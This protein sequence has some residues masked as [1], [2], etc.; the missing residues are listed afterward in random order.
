MAGEP[1]HVVV[2]ATTE[3]RTDTCFIRIVRTGPRD[4]AI[5]FEGH[6]TGAFGELPMRCVEAFTAR[7]R[8]FRVPAGVHAM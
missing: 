2:E 1:R 8:T 5:E 3:L 4:I 7:R 6:D